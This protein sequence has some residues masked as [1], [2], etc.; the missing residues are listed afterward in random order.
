VNN[1]L[2]TPDLG[3]WFLFLDR[4]LNVISGYNCGLDLTGAGIGPSTNMFVTDITSMEGIS[5]S[6]LGDFAYVG[7]GGNAGDP[8]P[9]LAVGSIQKQMCSGYISSSGLGNGITYDMTDATYSIPPISIPPN[10]ENDQYYPSRI[11]ELP[12]GASDGGFMI[13]GAGA[14]DQ[15]NL[16]STTRQTLFFL[17][18][19][20]HLAPQGA[21]G[22]DIEIYSS[23][24]TE[25]E[26]NA[27][28]LY[29]DKNKNE[30]WF[31]GHGFGLND[32]EL[33]FIY[34]KL[35]LLNPGVNIYP[36]MDA[37]ALGFTAPVFG[38]MSTWYQNGFLD[39]A[40][41]M[42][43][44]NSDEAAIGS[45]FYECNYYPGI[46]SFNA[47]TFPMLN[48]INY[49]DTYLD[50]F[51][52]ATYQPTNIYTYPRVP[53]NAGIGNFF[54]F[55]NFNNRQFSN[56]TAHQRELFGLNSSNYVLGATCFDPVNPPSNPEYF[57]LDGATNSI[58]WFY[59]DC[60]MDIQELSPSRIIASSPYVPPIAVSN[61]VLTIEP[62]V[63]TYVDVQL[64]YDKCNGMYEFKQPNVKMTSLE[65]SN[66][67]TDMN[68][69]YTENAAYYKLYNLLG[70]I[71][72][73]GNMNHGFAK[74]DISMLSSG[75]YLVVI[76]DVGHKR[77]DFKKIVK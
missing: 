65:L 66:N 29:F 61:S 46:S 63:L 74:A 54:P 44:D 70:E 5:S 27:S 21:G 41:I 30:V 56:H 43:T 35:S 57:V 36:T 32:G 16:N 75:A 67:S 45:N 71:V 8:S 40:K 59:N 53:G 50:N 33:S 72:L 49:N 55:L 11:I 25:E 51:T 22:N 31:A 60:N 6:G 69:L 42:I 20:Y 18:T 47:L 17:R 58:P 15:T 4:D 34:Q 48:R 23:L 62:L 10:Q 77:I 52:I 9:T 7:V 2:I 28:D 3:S 19:D 12:L 14:F 24:N 26:L 38:R 68:L 64:D 39:V 76:E 1:F 13:C 37:I 73:K